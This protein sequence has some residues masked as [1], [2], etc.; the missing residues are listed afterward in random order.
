VVGVFNGEDAEDSEKAL[1]HGEAY[2]AEKRNTAGEP[3]EEP[4]RAMATTLRPR[5]LREGPDQECGVAAAAGTPGFPLP[6]DA[7]RTARRR[8]GPQGRYGW[9]KTNAWPLTLRLRRIAVRS[10]PPVKPVVT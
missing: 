6:G 1:E 5:A 4:G 9:P 2:Q 7:D 8:S 10:A 3:A